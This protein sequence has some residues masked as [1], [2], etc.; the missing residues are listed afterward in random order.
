M[1]TQ[2]IGKISAALKIDNP[3][4]LVKNFERIKED[5]NLKK[6]LLS[7]CLESKAFTCFR[8]LVNNG[9]N[10]IFVMSYGVAL[11]EDNKD[12]INIINEFNLF[13]INGEKGQTL[14][15]LCIANKDDKLF[16]KIKDLITPSSNVLEYALQGQNR[17]AIE[18]YQSKGYKWQWDDETK[19]PLIYIYELYQSNKK[20]FIKTIMESPQS[21]EILKYAENYFTA[22]GE[23]TSFKKLLPR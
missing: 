18:I 10:E 1:E 2:F 11:R 8:Y 17:E 22:N 20:G 4:F 23:I 12:V 21:E 14:L 7:L 6:S 3:D 16:S 5:Q 13:D 19:N 9:F 15:N